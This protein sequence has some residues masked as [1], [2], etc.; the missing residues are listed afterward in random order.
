MSRV[1]LALV[2]SQQGRGG[3]SFAA[4]AQQHWQERSAVGG[5][6]GKWDCLGGCQSRGV[7]QRRGLGSPEMFLHLLL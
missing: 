7:E 1:L 6:P 5:L 4:P 2:V 3:L